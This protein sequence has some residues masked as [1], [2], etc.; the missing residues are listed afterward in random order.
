MGCIHCK[1]TVSTA[2]N[3]STGG[4]FKN[5]EGEEGE[6]AEV[7][8]TGASTRMETAHKHGND[9]LPDSDGK[10]AE[11]NETYLDSDGASFPHKQLSLLYLFCGRL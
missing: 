7:A 4:N 3:R 11:G 5:H 8:A 6:R 9:C 2:D 10:C 1:N